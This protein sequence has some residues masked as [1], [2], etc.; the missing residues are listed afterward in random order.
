MKNFVYISADSEKNA[1]QSLGKNSLALAGGTDILNLMKGHVIEPEALVNIK[2][3]P[4][5]GSIEKTSAG[6]LRIGANVTITEVIEDEAVASRFPALHQALLDIGGP[7]IRNMSTLGGNLCSRPRCWY[8]RGESFDCLKRGGS[9]C[10]A[11]EG[12]NE[13]HAIFGTD[14][15]CVMISPSNAAPALIVYNARARIAGPGGA[16][17][18]SLEKFFTPP[19]ADIA[20]ET[21]LAPNEI[22]T[23]ILVPPCSG[24]SATYEVRHKES[25]DWPL[26]LASVVLEYSGASVREARICLGAVAPVPWRA[27]A[28]ETALAGGPVT[29]ASAEQA[30]R[31]AVEGARPLSQNRYKVQVA[32]TAVKRAILAAATGRRI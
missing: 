26:A 12:D 25:H 20:R 7:Q 24:R 27:R 17:E 29:E 32:R 13:F 23:H 22:V 31:R 21:V 28:A 10:A 18:V 8:Y 3:V 5:T 15:K 2:G 16:R 30:A 19:S 6:A 9:G 1:V 4:G 11:I 14:E